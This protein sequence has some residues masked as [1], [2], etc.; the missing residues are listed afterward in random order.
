M[1]GG[2]SGPTKGDRHFL[3][4]DVAIAIGVG[5]VGS[6]VTIETY[7]FGASSSTDRLF[8]QEGCDKSPS[9]PPPLPP[10]GSPLPPPQPPTSPSPLVPL[11]QR[12]GAEEG[13]QPPKS[14]PLPTNPPPPPQTRV[15]LMR[16]APL[17]GDCPSTE[18]LAVESSRTVSS[19]KYRPV[20]FAH[21]T[22]T[23]ERRVV[24]VVQEQV[25][26]LTGVDGV[27]RGSHLAMPI[28]SR[29]A[30]AGL[31]SDLRIKPGV[32]TTISDDRSDGTDAYLIYAAGQPV[33]QFA[34]ID[35][36]AYDIPADT[37]IGTTV[38]TTTFGRNNFF[39]VRPDGTLTRDYCP[40]PFPPPSPRHPPPIPVLPGR[41]F[42]AQR[43]PPPSP[44][45]PPRP[46]NPPH[47][48][49]IRPFRRPRPRR[50]PTR[51][52]LQAPSSAS[53]ARFLHSERDRPRVRSVRSVRRGRSGDRHTRWL[54][55]RRKTHHLHQLRGLPRV[56]PVSP[57]L[58]KRLAI[59][60]HRR[61]RQAA[62]TSGNRVS[63]ARQQQWLP[64]G[65]RSK[66]ALR[67]LTGR[68]RLRIQ[69]GVPTS[70][71]RARQRSERL[72][73]QGHR[74][75]RVLRNQVASSDS[76]VGPKHAHAV[77]LPWQ[78]GGRRRA[79]V[80][81]AGA[82]RPTKPTSVPVAA[83]VAAAAASP[84]TAASWTIRGRLEV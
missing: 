79:G 57:L 25:V 62:R 63:S 13:D 15:V 59:R 19:E 44:A 8:V 32:I 48:R 46:P 38:M 12:F 40:S 45:P 64:D 61:I 7:L 66:P 37:A 76:V 28:S 80:R 34:G 82:A 22:A 18:V 84:D 17:Y 2:Q 39:M 67:Q 55:H 41:I 1:L 83:P 23:A 4:G 54:C 11:A 68:S 72:R 75:Q 50:P 26:A 3:S 31:V 56:L 42:E 81:S 69:G 29:S 71:G 53:P 49:P 21:S 74:K 70:F 24:Y 43:P 33:F 14:P 27:A 65:A 73:T 36:S 16:V 5:C 30:G 9:P 10:P 60:A 52:C 20:D 77:C 58:W 35:N 47:R 6:K 78:R 51:R